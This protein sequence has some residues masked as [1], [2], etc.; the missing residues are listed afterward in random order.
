MDLQSDLSLFHTVPAEKQVCYYNDNFGYK[1]ANHSVS[2]SYNKSSHKTQGNG[3]VNHHDSPL[4]FVYGIY[5]ICEYIIY[6]PRGILRNSSGS[7][8]QS[9]QCAGVN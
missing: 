1:H 2:V 9:R 4:I 7:I 5:V 8:H 3:Y 6:Q